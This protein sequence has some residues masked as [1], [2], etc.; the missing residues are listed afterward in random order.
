M[1]A[2]ASSVLN[3]LPIRD[4]FPK[5]EGHMLETAV[6]D[7]HLFRLIKLVTRKYCKVPSYHLGMVY[8]KKKM[9]EKGRKKLSKAI[10]FKNQ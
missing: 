10:H 6:M 7:N 9:G 4:I 3:D 2:I 8:S 1:D 5:L